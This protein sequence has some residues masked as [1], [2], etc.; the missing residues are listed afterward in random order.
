MF[1]CAHLFGVLSLLWIGGALSGALA[2]DDRVTVKASSPSSPA[3]FSPGLVDAAE[4]KRMWDRDIAE[5]TEHFHLLRGWGEKQ[6]EELPPQLQPT[7]EKPETPQEESTPKN[8][9]PEMVGETRES[10]IARYGDPK[11]EVVIVP[12]QSAPKPFKAIH[13]AMQ[14]GDEELAFQFARKHVRYL[15]GFKNRI[16][17]LTGMIA[18]AMEVEGLSDGEGWTGDP[19]FERYSKYVEQALKEEEE[20]REREWDQFILA[21]PERHRIRAISPLRGAS[22]D[23]LLREP[24]HR[25]DFRRVF[26]PITPVSLDGKLSMTLFVDVTDHKD[27]LTAARELQKIARAAQRSE[28]LTFAVRAHEFASQDELRG[29]QRRTGVVGDGIEYLHHDAEVPSS[30]PL[31]VVEIPSLKKEYRFE[32]IR[33]SSFYEELFSLMHGRRIE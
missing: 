5:P 3:P 2:A 16:G 32:G 33:R 25:A 11:G 17:D 29:F 30:L 8:K 10:I 31:L 7:A 14:I 9:E 21:L 28:A 26:A 27:S 22:E 13:A 1:R 19:E 15:A 18:K 24:E 20:A 6:A 23:E 12:E 4:P